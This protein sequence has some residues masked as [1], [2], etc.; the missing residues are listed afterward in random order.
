MTRS[1]EGANLYARLKQL[2]ETMPQ[3][4]GGFTQPPETLLWLGRAH[5]AVNEVN[6]NHGMDSSKFAHAMDNLGKAAP[7]GKI[8]SNEIPAILYRALAA[9]ERNAPVGASSGF[10]AVGNSFDALTIIGKVLAA[11]E[12]DVLLVDP[13]LDAN[14]L[15][16]FATQMREGVQ[17]RLLADE[18]DVKPGFPPAVAA[19][20]RQWD[21][22]R[23][24]QARL[25]PPKSIHDRFIQIDRSEIW[26][27]SQSLNA[28]AA[29]APATVNKADPDVTARKMPA[30]E[31]LWG[32]A[33]PLT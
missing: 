16:E 24:L 15:S 22:R 23:P 31:D 20:I 28:F 3:L 4:Q 10:I 13:Y 30:Y 1:D 5:A 11:A 32:A 2:V 27:L 33:K 14:A 26:L 21:S 9:A 19:W 6:L 29:R 25:S 17:V 12:T 18:R 7:L 8:A